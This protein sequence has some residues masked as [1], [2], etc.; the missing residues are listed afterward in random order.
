[1]IFFCAQPI[2]V[3]LFQRGFCTFHNH[4][5]AFFPQKDFDTFCKPFSGAFLCFSIKPSRGIVNNYYIQLKKWVNMFVCFVV[6]FFSVFFHEHSRF[7]T[8]QGKGESISLTPLY[9]FHPPHRH[10]DISQGITAESS[11]LHIAS[12]RTWT[13]LTGLTLKA[14]TTKLAPLKHQNLTNHHFQKL[15]QN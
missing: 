11:P 13:G 5:I 10:I 2:S 1:M 8:E 9:H 15:N 12:N 6:F 3:L 14:L 4:I 7:T